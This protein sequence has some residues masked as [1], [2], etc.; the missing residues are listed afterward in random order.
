MHFQKSVL[1]DSK[2]SF[3][4]NTFDRS[5]HSGKSRLL[6]YFQPITPHYRE[7]AEKNTKEQVTKG[8]V[9]RED[10]A[11]LVEIAVQL[12]KKRGLE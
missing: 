6:R 5:L 7:M 8:F 10:A 3:V 9:C 1:I 12:A 4:W 2:I 11:E